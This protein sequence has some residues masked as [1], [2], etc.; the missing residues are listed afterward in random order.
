MRKMKFLWLMT[1]VMALLLSGCGSS[2]FT[3]TT[4][5]EDT[6]IEVKDAEDGK[7]SESTY[8]TIGKNRVAIVES[9]LDKGELKIDFTEVTVRKE[10]EDDIEEVI[11]GEVVTSVT[12]GVGEK[13]EVPIERG[14]YI[15]QVTTIGQTNGKVKVD[16]EKK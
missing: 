15:L 5:G 12:V 1:L 14:D 13:K 7:T 3:F 9:S 6:T 10:T 16:V 8:F 2:S 11:P 4:F